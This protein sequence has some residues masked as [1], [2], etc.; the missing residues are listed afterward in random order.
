M[1]SYKKYRGF[2]LIEL[3]VVLALLAVIAMIALPSTGRL[4]ESNR[5]TSLGNSIIGV[6]T[7]ARTEALRTGSS[8]S[9]GP[10]NGSY[11]NGLVAAVV[12]GAVL[13]QSE[14]ASGNVAVTL[15]PLNNSSS[16]PPVFRPNGLTTQS[17]SAGAGRF[18]FRV[19][20]ASGSNGI[21]IFVSAGGQVRSDNVVCP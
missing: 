3:L 4:I 20:G 14:A 17:N 18:H 2:T 5:I 11:S 16:N 8:V 9:V 13:R 10:V 12:G 21:D 1:S 15:N 7:T 19:C 6:V